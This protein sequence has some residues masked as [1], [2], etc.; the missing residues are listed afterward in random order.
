MFPMI[1]GDEGAGILVEID[2]DVT[3]FAVGDHVVMSFIAVCGQCRWCAIGMGY[4]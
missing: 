4:V 1:G 3:D 2:D